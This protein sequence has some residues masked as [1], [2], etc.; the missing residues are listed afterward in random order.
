MK[1]SGAFFVAAGIFLSRIFGLIRER[2]FAHYFGNSDAGDAFKAALKIPNFLQNLFGEGVLSAS[3]IPVYSK[4]LAEGQQKEAAQ[5]ASTVATFLALTVSVFVL[6]G[7]LATEQLIDWIA[8][9]FVGEKRTLT[10]QLVQIFFPGTGVLVLS[11]WCLGV[12]NSHRRFFL[13]Y[14]APV[15]WN[16][17]IIA[18]MLIFAK[19]RSQEQLAI[20]TAWGLVVGSVLQF[21]VQLPTTLKVIQF[22]QFQTKITESVKKVFHQFTPV[23][24]TRGVVQLSAY[25]DSMIASFLASG[26]ISSISYA[27]NLYMLPISLFGMSI[28]ASEL[29]ELSSASGT[30]AEVQQK[31]QDRLKL[32]LMRISY[33]VIPTTLVFIGLGGAVVATLYQTGAFGESEKLSVW[34]VLIGYS[35]GLLATTQSRL[36][37]SVFYAMQDS[38]TPFRFAVIRILVGKILGYILAIQFKYEALGLALA[39]GVSGILEFYLLK[40][41]LTKKIG[42]IDFQIK[43]L[44]KIFV[45]ALAASLIAYMSQTMLE[46]IVQPWLKGICILT[47]FGMFYLYFTFYMKIELSRQIVQKI[48]NKI[49]RS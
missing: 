40:R 18:A 47:I 26:A 42:L 13:S 27:Q 2:V 35:L 20:V 49:M 16:I 43:I 8:P 7:V 41:S 9:G 15:F 11:A 39:G 31:I 17:A 28:A 1:S 44:F 25:I 24:M 22:F 37:S 33:F 36:F 30:K 6:L 19:G 12:L 14:V 21:L 45:A 23:V 4:L 32:S 3:L 5:V 34:N 29:P 48:Q 46:A 38:R 10:I